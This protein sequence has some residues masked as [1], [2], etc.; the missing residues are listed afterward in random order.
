[1]TRPILSLFAAAAL[2]AWII[3]D[4]APPLGYALLL[5]LGLWV[6]CLVLVESVHELWRLR[7]GK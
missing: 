2:A 7:H 4:P 6:P 5:S 1:M 3:Q